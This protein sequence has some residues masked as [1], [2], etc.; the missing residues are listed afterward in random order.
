M[1][2]APYVVGV[3]LGGSKLAA[4]LVDGTGHIQHRVWREHHARGYP[5]VLTEI[6]DAVAE[7]RQVAAVVGGTLAGVGVAVAGPLSRDRERVLAALNLNFADAPL[8]RDLR[9]R[10]GLVV[11]LENDANAA[12]LAE[13]RHG[14]GTGARSLVL[15]TLGTGIGGGIVVDGQV[16]TGAHGMAAELGHVQVARPGRRCDCGGRG[17]LER[18]ASGPALAERAAALAAT[19]S[20]PAMAALAARTPDRVVTAPLVTR[21]AA[22][23]DPIA[24]RLLAEAGELIGRAA[25][26]LAPVIDPDLV[27]LA[28]G[29]AQAGADHLLPAVRAAFA[30]D[31]P[32]HTRGGPVAIEL[33]RHGVDAGALGAAELARAEAAG[34]QDRP[35]HR[36]LLRTGR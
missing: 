29:L 2:A 23:G 26:T 16:L 33:A 34:L 19:G 20:A 4:L 24:A 35:A 10:V 1:T 3:D 6:T 27:L 7:C 18:Y 15:L 36:P 30:R 12:A 28:G 17:C 21:A 14:G 5:A 9:R 32:F 31:R 11:T 8:R 13:H 22:A 25:A